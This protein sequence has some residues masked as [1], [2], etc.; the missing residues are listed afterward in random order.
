MDRCEDAGASAPVDACFTTQAAACRN[1]GSPFTAA[2][3]DVLRSE[4]DAQSAF[5]RRILGWGKRATADALALRAAGALHFLARSGRAPEL[6]AAY[7][8]H[9][10]DETPL[11]RALA[12]AVAA[13]D[14]F[15]AGFLD[16]PPQTNETARSSILLGGALHV[17]SVVE[18]PLEIL[19][20]GASAGLNLHFD[21]YGYD[22]GLGR[23]GPP[24]AALRLVCDWRGAPP[25]LD[26][27]LEIAERAG[28]DVAPLDPSRAADRERLLAYVWPDQAE[29]LARME[30]A[31][32]LAARRDE[33]VVRADAADF[34][35]ARLAAPVAPG[36]ARLLHHTIVW[37]YLPLATKTRAKALI[38]TAGAA[39]TRDTP[40]AWLR[41]EADGDLR[42][43]AVTLTLWPRGETVAL[44]RAD[45]HGRWAQWNAE[46][47]ALI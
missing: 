35:A 13:H 14:D 2:L 18:R 25:P 3:C 24:D 23:W 31:L 32:T 43:A 1:L 29:R 22:L 36:R 33:R 19:E 38:E 17:A 30:T 41:M 46:A 21:R 39:A 8:P 44:G 7:P 15:L 5:G 6:A 47:P 11:R 27:P 16:R 45:F 34:L 4:V 10:F 40:F 42:S 20:L 9:D 28:C 37:Q 26:A 12:G